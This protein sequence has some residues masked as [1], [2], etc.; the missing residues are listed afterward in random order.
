MT[1]GQTKFPEP[2][3]RYA[4]GRRG[5]RRGRDEAADPGPSLSEHTMAQDGE[6]GLKGYPIIEREVPEEAWREFCLGWGRSHRGWLVTIRGPRPEHPI[7]ARDRPLDGFVMHGDHGVS[8][9]LDGSPPDTFEI[10]GVTR[11]VECTQNGTHRGLKIEN[12]AGLI[13]IVLRVPGVPRT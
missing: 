2:A 6:A 8:A 7:L 5:E 12:L 3:L 10:E 13:E 9:I 4:E 11:I 1:N